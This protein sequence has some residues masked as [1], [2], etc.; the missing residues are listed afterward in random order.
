MATSLPNKVLRVGFIHGGRIIDERL[1]RKPQ[2]ITVGQGEKNTF[3]LPDPSLPKSFTVLELT[4]TGYA[5]VFSEDMQGRVRLGSG[6]DVD[7]ASLRAQGTATQRGDNWVLGLSDQDR[8]KLTLGD[9]TL[10][11]Q[12][13]VPP[14]EATA[15][16]LPDSVRGSFWQGVDQ[17]F[18]GIMSASLLFFLTLATVLSLSPLPEE[19]E[20]SLEELPDRYARVI[21]P[22]KPPEPEKPAD[23]GPS[24]DGPKTETKKPEKKPEQAAPADSK[25]AG[26]PAEAAARTAAIQQRVAQSGLLKILGTTGGSGGGA[27]ADVLGSAGT[28]NDIAAALAGAGGVGV[29]T[30]DALL[31]GAGAGTGPRG[32]ATGEAVGIGTIATKGAGTVTQGEKKEVEIQAKT[33]LETAEVESTTVDREGL[34]RYVKSRLRA[35]TSC[36]E[37]EL[38]RNPSLKGRVV[39]RFTIKPDGRTT[40]VQVDENTV[41]SDAVA[42]CIRTL[43]RAWTFPFKPEEEATVSYPF[44]FAPAN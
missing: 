11:F 27:L 20:L 21:I 22:T 43:I 1:F 40:D 36:Y 9:M 32:A 37:K 31:G 35:I 18:A 7:F 14:P 42:Q 24:D 28:S 4:R 29:A 15:T 2:S 39:V 41:G 30:S 33:T 10:L 12:F 13:V 17:V 3:Y 26:T 44:V 6:A 16:K 38:K 23:K 25:P 8:G 34:A 19:P 5:L